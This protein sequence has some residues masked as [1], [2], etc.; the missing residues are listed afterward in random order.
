MAR[1]G[2]GGTTATTALP[3]LHT[4]F[5][6]LPLAKAHGIGRT[7]HDPLKIFG[8]TMGTSHFQIVLVS[9]HKNL[10]KIVTFQTPEFK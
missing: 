8:P 7:A 9:H 3:G 10:K 1:Q 4:P 6:R 2:H 5:R